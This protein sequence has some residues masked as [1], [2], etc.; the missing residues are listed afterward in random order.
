MYDDV[1]KMLLLVLPEQQSVSN[2]TV[3]ETQYY[4]DPIGNVYYSPE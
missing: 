4:Q 1:N 3:S 2:V